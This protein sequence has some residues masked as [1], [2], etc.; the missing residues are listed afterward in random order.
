[1]RN[2]YHL[3]RVFF[4]TI[5]HYCF[6]RKEEKAEGIVKSNNSG[7]IGLKTKTIKSISTIETR[8]SSIL[9]KYYFSNK[10]LYYIGWMEFYAFVYYTIGVKNLKYSKQEMDNLDFIEFIIH[11]HYVC[12]SNRIAHLVQEEEMSKIKTI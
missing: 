10:E 3:S 9:L 7:S 4:Y 12:E 6:N 5:T 1:M 11:T 2:T 8:N